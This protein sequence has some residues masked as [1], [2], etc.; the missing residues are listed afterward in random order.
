MQNIAGVGFIAV[1]VALLVLVIIL[2]RMVYIC[3]PNAVLI[4][5]GGHHKLADGRTI[6]YR[7]VQGGRGIRIPLVEVVDRMDLTNMMIEL[8][9]G[10]A[11][12]KG[13]IPLNVQGV[14]NVKV[15]SKNDQLANAIERLLGMNRDQIM[16]IA[17]E[18]LEGNLRGVLSTLTPEEV[19][20]DREK[21]AGELLHE[22]DHD[23][24]RL[25]LELDTLKIQHVSD[26]KGYLSSIGRRQTAELFKRSRIAEAEN[27]ALAAEN[28]AQNQQNQ[29]IAKVD[30]EIRTV[31]AE[32]QRRV[33]EAQ[34]R[35]GA[36][37]AESK[38]QVLAQLAKA[39]AEVDV[40]RARLAQ[41]RY[42]LTADRVKPAEA[43]K[44]QLV[45]EAKGKASRIIE[46][47]KATASAIRALGAT[48]AKAGDSARQIFVA[49]KLEQ[50]V[51]TMM[52]TV[53]EMQID[54]LT[55]IDK[56]LA[57]N[58]GNFAVKA[59]VTNEQLKQMLG[60]DLA[61]LAQRAM[62]KLPGGS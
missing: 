16:A 9:V 54:K 62:P 3:P 58:G 41:V 44:V 60:V 26:D 11:Y 55:V 7:V 17:R 2:R 40:Q 50:L 1:V 39:T 24:A 59:A 13:G 19:N 56:E 45:Q 35:K 5:S 18:T 43:K 36:L 57:G 8:K 46:D 53:G 48:W 38:G 52:Q 49:Q 21:F 34:T 15:S 61:A 31:R 32:G 42:K 14:A 6:G 27:A 20:T 30:A 25:G 10:G 33:A 28:S 4:F 12:S 37:I 29:E 22:A 47:G 51:G 23:L